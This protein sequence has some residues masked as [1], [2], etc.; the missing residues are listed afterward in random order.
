MM[1]STFRACRSSQACRNSCALC[2]PTSTSALALHHSNSRLAHSPLL[3]PQGFHI[4]SLVSALSVCVCVC[5]CVRERERES[6]CVHVCVCAWVHVCVRKRE[7]EKRREHVCVF[8]HLC[9]YVCVCL[10]PSVV[11]TLSIY[12]SVQFLFSL[13]SLESYVVSTKCCGTN[14]ISVYIC[15]VLSHG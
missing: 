13:L 10:T 14:I 8:A 7:R 4:H 6:V 12:F 9:Q 11:C 3:L 1:Y 15:T 2:F 5:V